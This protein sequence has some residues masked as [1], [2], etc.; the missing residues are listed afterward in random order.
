MIMAKLIKA[1]P[2]IIKLTMVIIAKLLMSKLIIIKLNMAKLTMV[3]TYESKQLW[4][5]EHD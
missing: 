2:L 5:I 1:I 4:L 3:K